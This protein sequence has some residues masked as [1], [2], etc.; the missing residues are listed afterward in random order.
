MAGCVN[1]ASRHLVF[2]S[3]LWG[4]FKVRTCKNGP[5]S[6]VS[7]D[8]GFANKIIGSDRLEADAGCQPD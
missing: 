4:R 7:G 1:K 5:F 6:T 8:Y 3:P 2:I